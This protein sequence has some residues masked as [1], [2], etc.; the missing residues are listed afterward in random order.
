[1]EEKSGYIYILT[2][3]SF[4]ENW[5]K[6]G[7]ADDVQRRVNELSN[8]S[9]PFPFEIYAYYEIPKIHG[10][11]P[12]K[13]LHE[14][15]QTLNP[16]LRLAQNREFFEIAP[17][18]AFNILESMAIIHNRTD[19]LHRNPKN[20][21]GADANNDDGIE[22]YTVETHFPLNS[23]IRSLYESIKSIA[24]SVESDLV[25]KPNKHYVA[26]RYDNGKRKGNNAFTLRPHPNYIEISLNVK[27]GELD[28][29]ENVAYDISNRMWTNSQYAI[30]FDESD[31]TEYVKKLISQACNKNKI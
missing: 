30:K 8:T 20:E 7:Y 22:E 28:D 18:D 4:K 12:D 26:F 13:K 15:I 27:I 1:M 9:L 19:K 17:W 10:S 23:N 25:I 21:Y 11:M 6:I 31:D 14:L 29:P 2:N 5:I 3:K 16:D 24:L